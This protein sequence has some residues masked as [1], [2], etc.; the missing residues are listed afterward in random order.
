M[1]GIREAF[2]GHVPYQFTTLK[3][4]WFLP[5]GGVGRRLKCLYVTFIL[6]LLAQDLRDPLEE[7]TEAQQRVEKKTTKEE[8]L[9]SHTDR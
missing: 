3:V 1:S 6:Y 4:L 8:V 5:R 9:Q 7:L 2:Q